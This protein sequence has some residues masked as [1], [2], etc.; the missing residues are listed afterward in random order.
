MPASQHVT[1]QSLSDFCQGL[2]ERVD[3]FNKYPSPASSVFRYLVGPWL[4]KEL[5][6]H[7][8]GW[9]RCRFLTGYQQF[10]ES[11]INQILIPL[12]GDQL[13]QQEHLDSSSTSIL[14]R[15]QKYRIPEMRSLLRGLEL[16]LATLQIFHERD[17]V[18]NELAIRLQRLIEAYIR[19]FSTR[20]WTLASAYRYP[21]PGSRVR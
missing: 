19:F 9:N 21:P 15:L 7:P 3:H 10:G 17:R 4:S 11:F 13:L 1:L 20:T 5:L 2:K 18:A 6:P 16:R 8:M 14:G 12:D